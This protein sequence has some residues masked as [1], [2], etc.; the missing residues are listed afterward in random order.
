LAVRLER[1]RAATGKTWEAL[2]A[3][4]GVKRA[5]LFHVVAGRRGFSEKTLQRLLECEV[6]A[7]VRSEASALI[8]QGL[9]GTD[10]VAALLHGEAEGKSE[11]T[12][13]DI[14][15]GSKEVALEYRRGTP[16]V[17]YPTRLKVTAAGNAAV[18]KVIGEKGANEDPSRLLASCVPDLATKPDVLDRVTPSCYARIL[19]TALDLTFGLKWRGRLKPESKRHK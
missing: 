1:L 11:V 3:D 2:A 4:L 7:G 15:T 19:D 16:P 9:R 13:E 12:V 10:L 5:M 17:G 18:W 14:D 6:G 8:E